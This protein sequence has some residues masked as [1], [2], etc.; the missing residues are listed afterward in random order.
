[1]KRI[2]PFFALLLFSAS[3]I[4]KDQPFRPHITGIAYV[5]LL[6]TDAERSRTFYSTVLGIGPGPKRC[7][8]SERPCF[9]L[10]Q[11]QQ[12]ELQQA[13]AQAE[14]NLLLELAFETANALE[15]RRYLLANGTEATE[16][17]HSPDGSQY[18]EVRDPEGHRIVFIQSF[19]TANWM[20]M[21]NQVS[22]HMIHAG[23]VVHDRGA[24][25]RFYKDI[26]GFHV[27]W[28]GGRT[29]NETS[30]VDMQ[31]PDGTD[32]LEYMLNVPANASHKTLGVMNHIAL[33]VPDIHAAQQQLIKNGW[34]QTEEPK[35][36]RDGKWQLNLYDPDET[37]VELMEFKPTKEPCCSSYTGPHPGPRQ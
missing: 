14:P 37:R 32:W 6:A 4:A 33:G 30:W 21:V 24:E 3:A 36:G 1:M 22:T 18:F 12:I 26:L 27:Y 2:T 23:F 25:D 35:I 17:S 11:V 19:E 16:L 10:G 8:K 34:K 5:R 31:V 20:A 7:S 15:L 29:E 13:T 28:H 9:S